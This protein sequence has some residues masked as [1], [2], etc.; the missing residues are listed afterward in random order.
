MQILPDGRVSIKNF[1]TKEERIVN[2][3]DLAGYGISMDTYNQLKASYKPS[4][5]DQQAQVNLDRT[6]NALNK[7]TA[8]DIPYTPG[9]QPTQNL[10]TLNPATRTPLGA[11]AY[12]VETPVTPSP[13]ATPLPPI[14]TNRT[15]SFQDQLTDIEAKR[16][17][18]LIWYGKDSATREQVNDYW[19]AEIEKIDPGGTKRTTLKTPTEL[20]KTETQINEV[21]DT[22]GNIDT[23][24]GK[25]LG[26][27]GTFG[28]IITKVPGTEAYDTARQ[29]QQ[30]KDQLSLASVGK[31]KGQGQVSD[32]E[33]MMLANAAT[34]LDLGMTKEAFKAELMKMKKI[35]NR[36]IG[37]ETKNEDKKP[38]D[39][40][41]SLPPVN[42]GFGED[43]SKDAFSYLSESDKLAKQAVTEKDPAKKAALLEKSRTLAGVGGDMSRTQKTNPITYGLGKTQEFLSGTEALP[44]IGG[45]VGSFAGPG[46]AAIGAAEGQYL[47]TALKRG[48]GS[49]E[50][51]IKNLPSNLFTA[52]EPL[53][54]PEVGN[55]GLKAGEYYALNKIF[56][57]GGNYIKNAW[58]AKTLNPSKIAG[59]LRE[60]AAEAT[61]TINTSEIIKA[62]ER[63]AKL[64]PA[65][66]PIWEEM[67]TGITSNM[68]TKDLLDLLTSWGSRTW[69]ISGNIKDKAAAQIMKQVYGAGRNT[70]LSQAP[71][72]AKHTAELK[73]IMGVPKMISAAQKG[74]W[75]LLKLLGIGKL[76]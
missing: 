42:L 75:F 12:K 60:K 5:A 36:S 61:P 40:K 37:V 6:T 13:K 72:V 63:W 54:L 29:I 4:I 62:G 1:L 56:S 74:T 11:M 23:I 7:E 32:A 14:G 47:K 68:P 27:I 31:L 53:T 16:Q 8:S 48:S 52:K 66:A 19:N 49:G 64:D 57:L 67:K 76:L 2:P 21:K 17:Q 20:P 33:R 65:S 28:K 26:Y 22:I 39:S 35:L 73:G 41:G 45:A 70:I 3:E 59:F 25:D 71:E 10:S 15:S 46:G 44:M 50:P 24:L 55:I 18:D 34:T 43:K 9:V 51:G 58:E 30:V 38:S 69:T